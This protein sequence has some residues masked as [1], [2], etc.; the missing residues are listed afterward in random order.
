M[1]ARL[2]IFQDIQEGKE[3]KTAVKYFFQRAESVEGDLNGT[4][5]D[6]LLF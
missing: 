4:W 3:A 1:S 2:S 6:I 5:R